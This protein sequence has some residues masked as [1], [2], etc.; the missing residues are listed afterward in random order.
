MFDFKVKANFEGQIA[1]SSEEEQR[2]ADFD[3]RL[4]L[5]YDQEVTGR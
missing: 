1:D 2:R 4:I 3:V 5:K